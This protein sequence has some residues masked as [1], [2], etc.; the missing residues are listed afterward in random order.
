MPISSNMKIYSFLKRHPN[1][2]FNIMKISKATELS[3]PTVRDK[4]HEL[5]QHGLLKV[6]ANGRYRNYNHEY[7]YEK[8][9]FSL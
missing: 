6:R 3:K 7:L 9:I 1:R 5:Y 8:D 2:W 4:A